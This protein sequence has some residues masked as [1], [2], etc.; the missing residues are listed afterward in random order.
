MALKEG[1][2]RQ[3]SGEGE[4]A[5]SG[6]NAQGPSSQINRSVG[7]QR[8]HNPSQQDLGHGALATEGST[9]A[10]NPNLWTQAS[11]DLLSPGWQ[12]ISRSWRMVKSKVPPNGNVDWL[13]RAYW[14]QA[15]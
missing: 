10:Q 13:S 12:K 5:Q 4:V 11:S 1:V 14:G 3:G 15:F 7:I 6:Q 8:H 2:G 9:G